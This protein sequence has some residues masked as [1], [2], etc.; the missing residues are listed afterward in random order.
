MLLFAYEYLVV[1]SRADFKKTTDE[2]YM[3]I[4]IFWLLG[5]SAKSSISQNQKHCGNLSDVLQKVVQAEDPQQY[6]RENSLLVNERQIRIMLTL[7]KDADVFWSSP[8]DTEL[9]IKERHQVLIPPVNL[10]ALTQDARVLSATTP[11]LASSKK[12]PDK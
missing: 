9:S 11:K 7:K 8:V 6:A 3:K 4:I 10:C 2:D 12:S 1:L 5:C